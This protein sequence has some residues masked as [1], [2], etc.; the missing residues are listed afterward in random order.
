MNIIQSIEKIKEEMVFKTILAMDLE[1]HFFSMQTGEEIQTNKI[2]FYL[3][4]SQFSRDKSNDYIIKS[5]F[6][7]DQVILNQDN[8]N[9][10]QVIIYAK[11]FSLNS[12]YS[13]NKNIFN[14]LNFDKKFRPLSECD[15]PDDFKRR[16]SYYSNPKMGFKNAIGLLIN[17][18]TVEPED[19]DMETCSAPYLK[20]DLGVH[21]FMRFIAISFDESSW[22][23]ENKY[24]LDVLYDW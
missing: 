24:L 17:N 9:V 11:F 3:E 6:Y 16:K 18:V 23:E 19:V 13:L 22:E 10:D 15:Y 21:Q 7:I 8:L 20:I 1:E 5:V 2:V 14:K 12:D 4:N